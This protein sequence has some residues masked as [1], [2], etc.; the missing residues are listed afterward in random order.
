M[1][2]KGRTGTIICCFMLFC[3]KKNT[4]FKEDLKMLTQHLIIIVKKDFES[5]MVL[6][7]H[8]RKDMFIILK[9]FLKR[10]YTIPTLSLLLISL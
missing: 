1:A 5:E 10:K 2:G 3:G 7:S 6:H 8:H 4:N 9:K